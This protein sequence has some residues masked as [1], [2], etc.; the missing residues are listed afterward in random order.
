MR[1][2]RILKLFAKPFRTRLFGDKQALKRGG[3]S[4]SLHP[5]KLLQALMSRSPKKLH[6]WGVANGPSGP[7]SGSMGRSGLTIR[8]GV[9][10]ENGAYM[11]DAWLELEAGCNR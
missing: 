7:A 11:C 3:M 6:S 10:R 4:G 5:V 8:V 2:G 1:H 9:A